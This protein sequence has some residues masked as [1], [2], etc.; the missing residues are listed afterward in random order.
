[1][2]LSR[3]AIVLFALALP[4]CG[5]ASAQNAARPVDS[6]HNAAFGLQA[7]IIAPSDWYAVEGVETN[8]WFD[9]LLAEVAGLDLVRWEVV[10]SGAAGSQ[11]DGKWTDTPADASSDGTTT[12]IYAYD[13]AGLLL[14]SHDMMYHVCPNDVNGIVNVL[15]IGDSRVAGAEIVTG[16]AAFDAADPNLTINLIGT[17]DDPYFNEGYSGTTVSWFYTHAD[18]PFTK[19]G[20]WDYAAYLTDNSLATPDVVVIEL[21]VNDIFFATTDASVAAT[22]AANVTQLDAMIASFLVVNSGTKTVINL[23]TLPSPQTDMWGDYEGVQTPS[24]YRRNAQLYNAALLAHDWDRSV[25]LLAPGLNID[26]AN[27]MMN[28]VHPDDDGYQD[29]ADVVYAWI[30]N[31]VP[32]DIGWH[33]SRYNYATR[34]TTA[35]NGRLDGDILIGTVIR[36]GALDGVA[37]TFKASEKTTYDIRTR[38]WASSQLLGAYNPNLGVLLWNGDTAIDY[39]LP[40][41][42]EGIFTSYLGNLNYKSDYEQYDTWIDVSTAIDLSGA[43]DFTHISLHLNGYLGTLIG[44]T[45]DWV[46]MDLSETSLKKQ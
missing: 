10:Q 23:V 32:V 13:S 16:L 28:G 39:D 30:K 11:V 43:P 22:A 6:G 4:A 17:Q 24:R 2:Y 9:S 27:G 3:I 29:I 12:T 15:Y 14:A 31:A 20:V 34:Q 40:S 37:V 38:I 8:I 18:S 21:G 19:A 46:K 44:Q 45:G 42:G 41:G 5:L 33:D 1:M 25:T 35:N 7:Q 36:A 26:I